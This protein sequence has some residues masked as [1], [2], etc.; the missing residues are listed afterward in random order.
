MF[1]SRCDHLMQILRAE[2]AD[3]RNQLERASE[4][5]QKLIDRVIALSNPPALHQ[6]TP[7]PQPPPKA[8]PPPAEEGSRRIHWPG[9]DFVHGSAPDPKKNSALYPP[10]LKA[11][12]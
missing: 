3:L 8:F 7:R 10:T 9:T 6:V 4:E 2:N 11:E 12:K 5:R 1:H